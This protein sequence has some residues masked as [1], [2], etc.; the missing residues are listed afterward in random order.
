MRKTIIS[1]VLGVGLVLLASGAGL[2]ADNVRGAGSG[3]EFFPCP[4][5]E[6]VLL[7]DSR[8]DA[9]LLDAVADI[10]GGMKV[11]TSDCCV[12]GDIWRTTVVEAKAQ[13]TGQTKSAAGVVDDFAG[14]ITRGVAT[15]E[16]LYTV[17]VT[18]DAGVDIFPAEM[19]V[20]IE[21]A[22]TVTPR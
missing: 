15:G 22:V 9:F 11:S 13:S 10:N 16:H 8:A 20:C 4:G 7:F 18:Y 17:I 14:A 3:P 6:F 21:G 12:E 19:S 5:Q 2:A 1:G